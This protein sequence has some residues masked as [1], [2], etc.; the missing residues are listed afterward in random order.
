MQE[1]LTGGEV[2][3]TD[4]GNSMCVSVSVEEE[5]GSVSRSEP[6]RTDTRYQRVSSSTLSLD[7]VL[8][9]LSAPAHELYWSRLSWGRRGG[10]GEMP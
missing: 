9:I 8:K 4:R 3:V 10:Q 1:G 6:G 5:A 2:S 7:F